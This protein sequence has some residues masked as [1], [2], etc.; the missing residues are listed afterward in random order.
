[1]GVC[2]MCNEII[3]GISLK[4][5]EEFGNNYKYCVDKIEQGFNKPCFFILLLT[6]N[7]NLELKSRY[8]YKSNFDVH[9]FPTI[10]HKQ[11]NEIHAI[12]DRLYDCLEYITVNGDLVRGSSM[13]SEIVDGVLHFF[14]SYNMNLQKVIGKDEYME[15]VK[16]SAETEN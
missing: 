14:I 4:L 1:M 8:R 6:D 9:F 15:E 16:V 7:S 11:N 12:K 2:L 5:N 13:R 3:K 10:G